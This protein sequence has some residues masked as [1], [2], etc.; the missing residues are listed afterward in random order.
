[1]S[2]L[3][4]TKVL[5][6]ENATVGSWPWQVSIHLTGFG[7]ICGGSLIS[8]QWVLTANHCM[9]TTIPSFYTLYMGRLTQTGLNPHE[10]NRSVS[11]IIAHPDYNNSLFNNDIALMK[12]SSPVNFTN[13]I[14][15][16]CLASNASLFHNSTACWATGW[17][18][19]TATDIVGSEVLQE[20]QVPVIG[21]RECSCQYRVVP[22]EINITSAMICAGQENRGICQGDSGGPLQCEQGAAWIQAG[23]TSFGVPC[24][25]S[26]PEVYARVSEFQTWIEGHVPDAPFVTY[27]STGIDQDSSFVCHASG[28]KTTSSSIPTAAST[29]GV[30]LLLFTITVYLLK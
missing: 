17:G 27:N 23:I 13:F 24:A 1:M 9:I 4:H 28:N 26:I 18:R 15:P 14:S 7:H 3:C 8:N 25:I 19:L 16:I 29:T 5:G 20:V 22:Q 10:V 11:Q 2:I 6:G 12:L 30:H 21:N